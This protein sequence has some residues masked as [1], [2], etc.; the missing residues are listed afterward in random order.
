MFLGKQYNCKNIFDDKNND[1]EIY[2]DEISKCS[3][4]LFLDKKFGKTKKINTRHILNSFIKH[5]GLKICVMMMKLLLKMLILLSRFCFK[6][7]C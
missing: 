2:I 6:F 5:F 4:L 3:R 1:S 7:E